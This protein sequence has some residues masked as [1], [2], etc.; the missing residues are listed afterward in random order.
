MHTPTFLEIQGKSVVCKSPPPPHPLVHIYF[1]STNF[2]SRRLSYFTLCDSFTQRRSYFE[3]NVERHKKNKFFVLFFI[4]QPSV[5]RRRFTPMTSAVHCEP[6]TVLCELPA[7]LFVYCFF[8]YIWQ[9][10]HDNK[11]Y[12]EE[13]LI[14]ETGRY[15]D[16]T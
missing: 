8:T 13:L 4:F 16:S 15:Q 5:S 9:Y 2:Q 14:N 10:K 12:P 3:G 1:Y 11:L 6:P 7:V